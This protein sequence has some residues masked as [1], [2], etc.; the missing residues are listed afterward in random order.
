MGLQRDAEFA[1][2]FCRTHNDKAC[3]IGDAL[4]LFNGLAVSC[5]GTLV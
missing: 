2:A 5:F 4:E 3:Y 1:G